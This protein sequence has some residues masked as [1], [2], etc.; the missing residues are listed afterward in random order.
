MS[1]LLIV[2]YLPRRTARPGDASTHVATHRAHATTNL[3]FTPHH[4]VLILDIE[5]VFFVLVEDDR[6]WL[7][8]RKGCSSSIRHH[9]FPYG[10]TEPTQT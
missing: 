10:S 9:A 3:Q 2:A 7:P 5:A 1:T 8:D 4:L 6:L